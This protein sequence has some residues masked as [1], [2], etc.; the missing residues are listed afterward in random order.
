[1]QYYDLNIGY[2]VIQCQKSLPHSLTPLD[3]HHPYGR[4]APQ[5]QTHLRKMGMKTLACTHPPLLNHL[6]PNKPLLQTK[7]RNFQSLNLIQTI[8]SL[9]YKLHNQLQQI[10][11]KSSTRIVYTRL[12]EDSTKISQKKKHKSK[13]FMR[14][15]SIL[16]KKLAFFSIKFFFHPRKY[17]NIQNKKQ[18]R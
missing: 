15:V 5:C 4:K 10:P 6:L 18:P 16:T 14:W 3:V 2:T 13:I 7:I 1:M 17:I 8:K 12:L 11:A 9:I